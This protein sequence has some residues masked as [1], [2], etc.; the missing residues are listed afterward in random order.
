MAAM[1]RMARHALWISPLL[2]LPVAFFAAVPWL[3][4]ISR[5]MAIL[6]A[7]A[8]V[9]F[10]MSYANYLSYRALR[11]L[12]EVQKAG[13]AFAAQWGAPA[14]QAAFVLLLMLPPFKD[15][16]TAVVSKLADHPGMTVDATV[17]VFSLTVGFCG[18][19]LLQGIGTIVVRAL[20]WT[21]KR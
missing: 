11:R 19:V 13:A 2:L 8:V 6:I 7:A 10:V 5:P 14:G 1:P 12:D 15:V 17:V 18:L 16:A 4:T 3:E 21:V 20:W 9:I